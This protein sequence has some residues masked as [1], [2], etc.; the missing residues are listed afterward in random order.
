MVT[1]DYKFPRFLRLFLALRLGFA[2]ALI[3]SRGSSDRGTAFEAHLRYRMGTVELKDQ[4]EGLRH[5]AQARI[6]AVPNSQGDFVS[7]IDLERVAITG[8]SYGGYL[9]LMAIAQYPE[10]FKI[11]IA[12]APVT[13]W[14][15]Y[16]TAYTER[17]MGLPGVNA[18]GYKRGSVIDMAEKFPD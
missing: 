10:V 12:G 1:N 6:G 16:D 2:V 11:A 5:L 9:S 13:Q 18:E 17:Y 14:E 4:I 7:V 3:D 8:W 15:L